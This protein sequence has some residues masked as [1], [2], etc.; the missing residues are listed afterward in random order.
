M[1]MPCD[2]Q[3]TL[4]DEIENVLKA[5][6]HSQRLMVLCCLRDG[7]DS[8]TVIARR[9]G[10]RPATVSHHL[11]ILRHAGIIASRRSGRRI[12]HSI[13]SGVATRVL[14]ALRAA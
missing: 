6:A 9:T 14:D 7:E 13:E 5:M 4:A 11:G 8:S 10:F 3:R 1:D 2:A 12:I